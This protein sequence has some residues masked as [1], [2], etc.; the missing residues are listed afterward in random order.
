[1]QRLRQISDVLNH[2]VILFCIACVLSMLAVSFIG[3]FYQAL[4]GDALSWTYSLARQ[5]IP[6]IGLLSITIAF[7]NGEHIAMTV[8]TNNVAPKIRFILE[9]LSLMAIA[10]LAI[11]L[12]WQGALFTLD[13]NQLVMISDQIQISQRWVTLSVP[14]TGF[15]LFI[16]LICGRDLLEQSNKIDHITC[17]NVEGE[18]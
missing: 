6:W 11:I 5:F 3:A 15:I 18:K 14:L 13:S 16:H 9:A 10:I 17:Q 7:K 2:L 8:L 12:I 4:T 1:M